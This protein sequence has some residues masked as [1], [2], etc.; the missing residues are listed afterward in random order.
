VMPT[1]Q[2]AP[3]ELNPQ[4]LEYDSRKDNQFP[5][6][7]PIGSVSVVSERA[8]AETP[9]DSSDPTVRSS[10]PCT[11]FYNRESLDQNFEFILTPL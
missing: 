9:G 11:R 4:R 1:P 5:S 3:S 6:E 8:G 10:L 7:A 2:F